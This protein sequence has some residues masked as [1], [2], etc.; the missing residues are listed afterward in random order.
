MQFVLKGKGGKW[1]KDLFYKQ[2][3][4]RGGT[5]PKTPKRRAASVVAAHA[6]TTSYGII[7]RR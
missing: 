6:P 1:G 5:G 4:K 7:C 2:R 3:G